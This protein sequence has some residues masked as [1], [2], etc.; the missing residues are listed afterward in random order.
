M[1]RTR[2]K[3]TPNS[4]NVNLC[5]KPIPLIR[6]WCGIEKQLTQKNGFY[7]EEYS[8]DSIEDYI[9]DLEEISSTETENIVF[10]PELSEET[11]HFTSI[12]EWTDI[13]DNK[14]IN[15]I[16]CPDVRQINFDQN[17]FVGY[18]TKIRITTK[19]DNTKFSNQFSES[20]SEDDD[21]NYPTDKEFD[22]P[23][24]PDQLKN[25]IKYGYNIVIQYE[26]DSGTLF[27]A[28]IDTSSVQDKDGR[29][30]GSHLGQFSVNFIMDELWITTY[31]PLMAKESLEEF[32]LFASSWEIDT[33]IFRFR[34]IDILQKKKNKLRKQEMEEEVTIP[35]KESNKISEQQ[36]L[37][38]L[39]R[40]MKLTCS[41]NPDFFDT[42]KQT[43]TECLEEHQE[44]DEEKSKKN[45]EAKKN[46]R[47]NKRR[48]DANL[49]KALKE[50]HLESESTRLDFG[51]KTYDEDT[52]NT[53]NTAVKDWEVIK[54]RWEDNGIL[55]HQLKEN[56]T[57]DAN[58][59][60]E[61]ILVQY[62]ETGLIQQ[63]W[64]QLSP[65]LSTITDINI[66]DD[67][68]PYQKSIEFIN[69]YKQ[70]NQEK[71]YIQLSQFRRA[72]EII[73]K[74]FNKNFINEEA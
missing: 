9:D 8:S 7:D 30:E 59:L 51:D 71:D 26:K 32:P 3:E 10:N 31:R 1:E 6:S 49:K 42:L 61:E 40:I 53:D 16:S 62:K 69:Y 48:K 66:L 37:S 70:H 20:D 14:I 36:T 21:W 13:M 68:N 65:Q 24:E 5:Q 73:L 46:A 34:P 50:I 55:S 47:R 4:G 72:E 38:L 23:F 57:K 33:G 54:T 18:V 22:R 28:R 43:V 67:E 44:T 25:Y 74:D 63:E 60:L 2:H 17:T 15:F 64:C 35:K 19:V 58:Q 56:L 45:N 29:M 41:D 52:S 12:E 39:E 27:S 11:K